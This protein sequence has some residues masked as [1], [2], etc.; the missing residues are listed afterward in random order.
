ML[1]AAS[2]ANDL[3]RADARAGGE[4]LRSPSFSGSAA[5]KAPKAARDSDRSVIQP[6]LR[7]H[8]GRVQEPKC[9]LGAGGFCGAGIRGSYAEPDESL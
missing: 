4:P 7:T 5:S 1:L 6:S 3:R 2:A 8:A 9:L